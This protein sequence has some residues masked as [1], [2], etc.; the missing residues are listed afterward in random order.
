[1]GAPPLSRF[2]RQGRTKQA[3]G[4]NN[5]SVRRRAI[6]NL[7]RRFVML[8]FFISSLCAFAQSRVDCATLAST[9][10]SHPVRY[11]VVLPRSYDVDSTRKF[12]VLYYFH[13]L[14]ESEQ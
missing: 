11:C 9:I 13:G 6:M 10:L 3:L 12:P 1:M 2:L 5:D 7:M 4:L 8:V 14:G